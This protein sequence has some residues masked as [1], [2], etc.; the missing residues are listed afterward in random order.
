M[1]NECSAVDVIEALQLQLQLDKERFTG[2]EYI[3]VLENVLIP[4]VR[5]TTIPHPHPIRLVHDRSPVH[6]CRVVQDWLCQH[7]EL[8]VLDW[9]PMG[10][11]IDPI[12][13]L[14][15]IMV[16]DWDIGEQR[17]IQA[18]EQKAHEVWES[19]IIVYS[20]C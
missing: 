4:S 6:M 10:C 8:E 11:D 2:Q 7:L 9:P 13:N 12:E 14:W 17:N 5:Y 16:R 20:I 15:G 1:L 19:D 3:D 18:I